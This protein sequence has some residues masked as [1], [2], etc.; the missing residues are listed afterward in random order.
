M[1]RGGEE[2]AAVAVREANLRFHFFVP[3][4]THSVALRA[5]ERLFTLQPK[6]TEKER[7]AETR[8]TDAKKTK[9]S[10]EAKAKANTKPNATYALEVAAN[11]YI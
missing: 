10:G 5:G 7:A 8:I 1:E 11:H 2:F 4:P 9:S 3:V 6:T